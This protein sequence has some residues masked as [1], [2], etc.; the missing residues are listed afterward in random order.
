M[1][2]FGLKLPAL[3]AQLARDLARRGL[4]REKVQAAVVSLLEL[5]HIRVGNDAYAKEN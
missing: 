5:T 4:P 1:I 2:A 3:R